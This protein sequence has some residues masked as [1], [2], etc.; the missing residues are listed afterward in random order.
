[1]RHIR[2]P[3]RERIRKSEV[4]KVV[5]NTAGPTDPY[6][7]LLFHMSKVK[8]IINEIGD[9]RFEAKDLASIKRSI[10]S[11]EKRVDNDE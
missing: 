10:T 7:A 1:M 8:Q 6:E 2:I 4:V 11:I 5:D 9:D 3:R